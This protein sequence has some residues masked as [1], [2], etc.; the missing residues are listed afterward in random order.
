MM[1]TGPVAAKM[2]PASAL[3][4]YTLPKSAMV[5]RRDGGRSPG[6]SIVAISLD[7][8]GIRGGRD[9]RAL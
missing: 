5:R 4:P 6:R 8:A 3:V 9:T 1:A 2:N 7:R